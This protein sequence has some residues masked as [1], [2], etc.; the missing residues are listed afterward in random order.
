[1]TD[2]WADYLISAVRYNSA[3]T[4]IDSVRV[5]QDKGDTVGT[6]SDESRATIVAALQM[7]TTFVTIFMNA[8]GT[9]DKGAEVRTVHIDGVNYIRTDADRTK[10]DNLDRLPRF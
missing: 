4:H 9:W 3:D 6:G 8:A 1:M 2:K 7:G 10:R 5:H